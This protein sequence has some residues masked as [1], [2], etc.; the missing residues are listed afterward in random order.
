MKYL[1]TGGA[2]FIG[3]HIAEELVNRGNEVIVYDDLSSGYEKNIAH[4]RG[5]VEFVKAD[6]RDAEGKVA[7]TA[8]EHAPEGQAEH[9]EQ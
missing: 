2:G 8:E 6:V 7:E 4:I 3:S 9:A 1:I 5:M